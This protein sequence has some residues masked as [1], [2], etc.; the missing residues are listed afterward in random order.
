MTKV[1]PSGHSGL[2]VNGIFCRRV[3][4]ELAHSSFRVFVVDDE[5]VICKTIAVILNATGIDAVPFDHPHDALEAARLKP[6]DLSLTDVIMPLMTGIELAVLVTQLCPDCKVL[7]LS[8]QASTSDLLDAARAAGH[9][10]QIL[11]KPIHP[12]ELLAHIR[13]FAPESLGR[14]IDMFSARHG[15]AT[16]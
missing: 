7:L 13:K 3:M 9:D 2:A 4:A 16:G 12:T 1:L 14:V 5:N 6:P 8:G 11:A 15:K 10:F